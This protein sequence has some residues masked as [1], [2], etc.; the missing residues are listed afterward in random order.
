ML[1]D[2]NKR[3][4]RIIHIILKWLMDEFDLTRKLKFIR[5]ENVCKET[6][7]YLDSFC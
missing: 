6:F 2:N 3:E 1:G 7:K 4:V 5:R